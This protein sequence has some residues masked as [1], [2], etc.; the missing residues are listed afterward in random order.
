MYI[1]IPIFID[2][3]DIFSYE[4]NILVHIDWLTGERFI[5][6]GK[7]TRNLSDFNH[8]LSIQYAQGKKVEYNIFSAAGKLG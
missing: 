3:L 2:V 1:N 6:E 7:T 8:H 5:I 4:N